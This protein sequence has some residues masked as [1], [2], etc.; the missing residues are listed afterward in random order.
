MHDS[1]NQSIESVSEI[2]TKHPLA[3]GK[4]LGLERIDSQSIQIRTPKS[5]PRKEA[6]ELE[7]L[8]YANQHIPQTG[9]VQVN[10]Q[11]FIYLDISNAY[12][13]DLIALL[14][15]PGV[16]PPP[17]FGPLYA[18]GAHITIATTFEN[19]PPLPPEMLSKEISFSLKECFVV[20][21]QNW[22]EVELLWFISV[23]ALELSHIRT[24][25]NLS[26]KLNGHDFHITFGV[27]KQFFS[28]HDLLG[29]QKESIIIK[30]PS[31]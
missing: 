14:D 21:P 28:I 9:T 11:G 15:I 23:E 4:C 31:S 19:H 2:F 8:A 17:Y 13:H 10:D 3:F 18:A 24:A 20:A 22:T 25:L 7:L 29:L 30:N 27:K 12:I 1:E 5:T 26:P 6:K 16:I